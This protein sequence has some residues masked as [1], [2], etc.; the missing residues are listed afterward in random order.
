M[1]TKTSMLTI[2]SDRYFYKQCM[3]RMIGKGGPREPPFFEADQ[4]A[5]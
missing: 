4:A 1:E 5:P 2:N 3:S